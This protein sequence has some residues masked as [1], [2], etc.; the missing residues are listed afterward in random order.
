MLNVGELHGPTCI[1]VKD[2]CWRSR[3]PMMSCR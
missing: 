2:I 1:Q 3:G